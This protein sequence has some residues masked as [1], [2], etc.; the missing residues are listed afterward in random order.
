VKFFRAGEIA[1]R[2][3]LLNVDFGKNT[4]VELELQSVHDL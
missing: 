2:A 4:M 3:N 1:R